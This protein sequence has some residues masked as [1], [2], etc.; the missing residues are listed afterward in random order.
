VTY[1]VTRTETPPPP[2][3]RSARIMVVDDD[4]L[5]LKLSRVHLEQAGYVVETAAGADEAL[6]KARALR[7]DAIM[8]DVLMGDVDGFG[9]CRRLREE[10]DLAAVPV[11]LVSTPY[12]RTNANQLVGL[13][14]QTRSAEQ[15]Y[16]TLFE[17]AND[18]ISVL[19]PEG[20]ILEVN[21]RWQQILGVPPEQIIGRHVRDLAAPGSESANFDHYRN[22]VAEGSGRALAAPLRR[23]DG[24]TI[25]M[26]FSVS[27]VEVE[28]RQLVLSIGHDVTASV[29]AARALEAAEE[30]YRSLVE[31]MP[32]VIWTATA[33]GTITFM[34]QN[35]AA[36]CGFTADEMRAEPLAQRMERIHPADHLLFRDS[37][38][39]FFVD[40]TPFDVE[41]RRQHKDGHWVWLR[42]RATARYERDGVPYVEG[43]MSDVSDRKRLEDSL[44]HA[45]KMEALGQLTGGIAHDFN[46]ILAAIL[47]STYFL[48]EEISTHDPRRADA[49]EIKE[50]VERAAALTR[51]LLAFS[52]RQVLEP[53]VA[54]L[55]GAMSGLEKMLKRL[56]GEDIDFCVVPGADL[57]AVRVDVGQIEQVIMNLVVNA[58]DA[59]PTGGK[60]TLETANVDLTDPQVAAEVGAQPGA[61]VMLAVSDTGSGI[62]EAIRARIFEPFFTTKEVGKGT[63]LGLSTCYG[64][65][66]QSG[67][68]ISVYSEPGRGSVFKVYLPRVDID[69]TTPIARPSLSPLGG[70]ETVLLIEDDEHVRNA[71]ERMLRTRGYRLLTACNGDAAIDLAS[72]HDGP[73]HLI[74][75]DVV[76]PGASGPE[77]ALRVQRRCA[78]ARALFMS[79]YTDHALLRGETFQGS[80][81]YLQK[82]FAPDALCKKVRDVLDA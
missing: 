56:I 37:F 38:Q 28:G 34:T 39:R 7:P 68:Y 17:H 71:V 47:G 26:E 36:V 79:G 19:S 30:K 35:V 77:V 33:D 14:D 13:L 15:R 61:Y 51:Q 12:P 67:G 80:V 29:E 70:D 64:I 1:I 66:Q 20:V 65:V 73:I 5:Q 52:R 40:G 46:N 74:L 22:A 25:Y 10:A 21:S 59:M 58:R 81:N 3:P 53:L 31:R 32:D 9:L 43:M 82:P 78:N 45:Q 54:D 11:I 6:S 18:A 42:S 2:A 72:R 76:M 41:Y 63:G 24:S 44:R 23:S 49:L 48:L 27:V 50:A 62:D 69:S 60:L 75:S 57:G 8:T 4:P 55:N 16:Q